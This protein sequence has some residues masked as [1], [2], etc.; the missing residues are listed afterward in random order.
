MHR[1][2][3]CT[4][5]DNL[6]YTWSL[7]TQGCAFLGLNIYCFLFMRSNPPKEQIFGAWTG[8]FKP[9]MQNIKTFHIIKSTAWISTKCHAMMKYSLWVVPKCTPQIQ[10]GS[11]LPSW[12]IDKITKSV[13]LIDW[14]WYN[15][16]VMHLGRLQQISNYDIQN[17]KIQ[18]VWK[19]RKITLSI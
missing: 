17:L 15:L 10:D 7:S 5:F 11:R 2:H 13:Q 3:R 1:S 12:K 18:L 4:D 8:I 16:S 14:F 9:N 19:T 6:Y